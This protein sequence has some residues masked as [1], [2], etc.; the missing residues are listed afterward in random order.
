MFVILLRFSDNFEN[1]GQFMSEHNKW[2][3]RGFD[4]SVFLLAGSIQP[5]L[6]GAIF[7]HD[8]S[9]S[10]LQ[11]R[12]NDD[13][14]VIENVVDAEILEVSPGKMDKRLQFLSE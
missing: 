8:T 6:G 9:M 5:K 2:V 1:A 11:K 4:D 7:A 13:P 10:E 14:F 12:V 3:Q